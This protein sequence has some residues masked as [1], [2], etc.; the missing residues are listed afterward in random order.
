MTKIVMKFSDGTAISAPWWRFDWEA[1]VA[2][3]GGR[4][5]AISRFKEGLPPHWS[6][7]VLTFD[8]YTQSVKLK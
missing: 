5:E 3:G 2:G 1:F 4:E 7:K 6:G 8:W